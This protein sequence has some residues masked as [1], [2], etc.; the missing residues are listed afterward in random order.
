MFHRLARNGF[1]TAD[2]RCD[3]TFCNN[4]EHAYVTRGRGVA[5][6]AQLHGVVLVEDHHAHLVAIFLAKQS[7]STH[8]LSLVNRNLGVGHIWNVL[9]YLLVNNLFHL[10]NLFRRHL[11]KVAKVKAQALVVDQRALLLNV[12]SKNLSQSSMHQVSR[13]MVVGNTLTTFRIDSG[14]ESHLWILRQLLGDM[15]NQVVFLHRI[16]N[17]YSLVF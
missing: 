10:T 11:G 14:R 1:D 16:N 6:A 17:T 13:T 4:F 15:N 2:A 8:R 12:G 3:G 9:A 7:R 5:A